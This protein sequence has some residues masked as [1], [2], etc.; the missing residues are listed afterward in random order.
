MEKN[1]GKIWTGP[2]FVA[3]FNNFF[4]FIV[5][6]ALLT[7]LPIYIL[8]DLNGT[9]GQAGLAMTIFMLSA[10]IVRPFSGRI[11]EVFGKRKTL[12]ISELLFCLS[13]IL[14]VFI[15]SLSLL[16]ALRFFHG[17]WFSIVTT[18]L[19]TVV[20]DI[21]PDSRKGT[22]LGYFALSMNLA[23]VFGPLIA[24]TIFQLYSYKVLILGL[25]TVIVIGYLSAFTLKVSEY[26]IETST[27]KWYRMSLHDLFEKKVIPSG[28]VGFLTA[29]AYASIMSYISVYAETRGVFE[30][31]SLFFIAFAI[32]MMAVR[33]FTGKMYD[34]RGP[35]AVVYPSF[36]FYA[37]G[38]ILLSTMHT[39]STLLIAGVLIGIGYGSVVPCLQALAIQSAPKHRSGHATSTFFT[40]FDSGIAIGAFVLGIVSAKW[41]YS[42]LYIVC[43]VIIFFTIPV[44][45]RLIGGKKGIRYSESVCNHQE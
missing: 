32:A 20:N 26:S 41:S 18:V 42:L 6:Y 22:G 43:G 30:S 44:Y 45:W 38:L 19:I 16:L 24:L 28:V 3:L 27:A 9:E 8:N 29:F 21:I 35:N 31:V 11:I 1:H 23:V 5:Y 36:I 17:I 4:L 39:V 12:L 40:I 37:A 34:T 10:I 33:P 13:T 25:A 14:Y 7:I 2:F 15:D